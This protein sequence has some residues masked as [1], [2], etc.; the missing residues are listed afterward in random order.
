MAVNICNAEK[1]GLVLDEF[2][3]DAALDNKIWPSLLN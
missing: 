2:T 1:C 3:R